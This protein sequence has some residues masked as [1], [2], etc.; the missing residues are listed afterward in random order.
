VFEAF[1]TEIASHGVFIVANGPPDGKD[2][3]NGVAETSNPNPTLMVQGLDWV[4]KNAGTGKYANVDKTR[5]AAAGQSCGGIQAYTQAQDDR[6][7]FIGIFNSGETSAS[8]PVPTKITKPIF[9]FLGGSTDIAYTNVT[10]PP[11]LSHHNLQCFTRVV[12]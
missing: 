10:K 11:P 7:S 2:N 3:P 9:Y 12:R 4:T 1:L 6:V 5:I 8:N